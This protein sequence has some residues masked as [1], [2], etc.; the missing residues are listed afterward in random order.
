MEV[1]KRFELNGAQLRIFWVM[2]KALHYLK[3]NV[4]SNPRKNAILTSFAY[5]IYP[6]CNAIFH[7]NLQDIQKALTKV[8]DNSEPRLYFA[9]AN[10]S[11]VPSSIKDLN[12]LTEIYLYS[13]RLATLPNEIGKSNFKFA[14]F[15]FWLRAIVLAV[16]G[17]AFC[18]VL[19]LYICCQ[20]DIHYT[21]ILLYKVQ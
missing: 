5:F 18:C 9:K 15:D 19:T 4:F 14:I 16:L 21:A 2:K 20:W 17:I 13:N 3:T 8:K 7:L 1:L 12:S 6:L 11:A 10:L